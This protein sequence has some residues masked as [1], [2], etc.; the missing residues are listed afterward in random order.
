MASNN[1]LLGTPHKVRRPQNADVQPENN[2]SN[3]RCG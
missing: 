1:A 3:I 2:E